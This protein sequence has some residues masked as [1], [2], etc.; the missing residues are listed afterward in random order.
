MP[1]GSLL[2]PIRGS[3]EVVE[4][5]L[6]EL[7]DDPEDIINILKAELAPLDLWLKFA[8]RK[9]FRSDILANISNVVDLVKSI[10]ERID[11]YLSIEYR[12]AMLF[13]SFIRTQFHK[14]ILTF[15]LLIIFPLPSNL[16]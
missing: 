15:P 9:C 2:I 4:V 16:L 11:G 6:A 7:P 14:S 8:V 1:A 12:K 10:L 3:D 13:S 5:K